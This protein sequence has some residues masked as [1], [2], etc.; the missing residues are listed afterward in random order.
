MF[1][2]EITENPINIEKAESFVALPENGAT[3]TFIGRVRNH[4]EGQNVQGVFYD[5]AP[6]IAK[7]I[8]GEIIEDAKKLSKHPLSIFIEHY[9]GYLAVGGISLIIC[10]GSPHRDEAYIVSRFIIENIKSRLPIWK[11]EHAANGE[12]KWQ[13]GVILNN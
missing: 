9:K 7:K 8:L 12:T 5:A 6:I 10:V 4:H 11:Q 1:H 13:D 3:L 2:Y